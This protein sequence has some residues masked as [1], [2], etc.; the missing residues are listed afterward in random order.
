MKMRRTIKYGI[1][2][3]SGYAVSQVGDEV[4]YAVVDYDKIDV[5]VPGWS[6][7]PVPVHLEKTKIW[8]VAGWLMGI[9]WTRSVPLE[10][11]NEHRRFW[12]LKPLPA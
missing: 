10:M 6:E 7:K 9:R 11:E 5:T 1:D 4:A 2:T 8:H 3:E 12:G